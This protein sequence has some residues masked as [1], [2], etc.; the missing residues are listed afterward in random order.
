MRRSIT[1]Y[2]AIFSGGF[3][4]NSP[5]A[6]LACTE[7]CTESLETAL[8]GGIYGARFLGKTRG[9]AFREWLLSPVRLPVPPFGRHF[10]GF[11]ATRS[12]ESRGDP[13]GPKVLCKVLLPNAVERKEEV[14]TFTPFPLPC[15]HFA[16]QKRR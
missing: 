11:Y 6:A 9:F 3:R 1:V 2:I 5:T 4:P 14:A 7:K 15:S 8:K 13:T 10:H 12:G 16:I